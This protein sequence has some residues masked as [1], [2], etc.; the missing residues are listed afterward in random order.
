M[1]I[2]ATDKFSGPNLIMIQSRANQLADSA[3]VSFWMERVKDGGFGW[4]RN[5]T[6]AHFRVLADLCGFDLVERTPVKE[7]ELERGDMAQARA[8]EMNAEL[9]E[10]QR[11]MLKLKGM[12]V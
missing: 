7:A 1:T 10:D 2:A 8:R 12:I 11:D 5:E 4:H 3:C 9:P 6:I